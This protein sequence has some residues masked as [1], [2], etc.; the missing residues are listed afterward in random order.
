MIRSELEY[1]LWVRWRDSYFA[2]NFAA[3][4]YQLWIVVII[5]K[6]KLGNIYSEKKK[7]SHKERN[8]EHVYQAHIN[9]CFTFDAVVLRIEAAT[10]VSLK[11]FVYAAKRN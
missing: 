3:S 6:D 4:W 7:A 8:V 1:D 11:G 10:L 9:L 2:F 5:I